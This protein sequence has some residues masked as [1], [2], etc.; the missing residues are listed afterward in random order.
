MS[1]NIE[2]DDVSTTVHEIAHPGPSR[3]EHERLKQEVILL[4]SAMSALLQGMVELRNTI[5]KP[6][7]KE[8]L[9]YKAKW[10]REYRKRKVADG[11]GS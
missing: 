8:R 3:D 5:K 11:R 10:Q 9:S 7:S 1:T 2:D 6:P 4:G